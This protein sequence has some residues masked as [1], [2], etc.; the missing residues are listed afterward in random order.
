MPSLLHRLKERRL[1]QCTL[2]YLAGAWLVFQGVEVLAEPWGLSPGVQRAIHVLL[3]IGLLVTLVLAWYHGERGR[4]RVSGTE[5]LILAALLGIAGLLLAVMGPRGMEESEA[6]REAPDISSTAGRPSIAVLPFANRSGLEGD[7]YFTEGIHDQIITQLYKIGGL[8]VRGRT[9][10]MG[11]RDSP[12]R[13]MDIGEELNVRYIVEG[14]VLRAG[15]EVRI[16][17]QLIDASRDE[18]LWAETY[19]Q[20]LAVENLLDVQSEVAQQ[21]AHAVGARLSPG[22]QARIEARPTENLRAYEFYLLGRY[23]WNRFTQEDLEKSIAH[24]QAAIAEDPNYAPAY[25]GLAD[26]Y[27]TLA[28]GH[29]TGAARPVDVLPKAREAVS[30]ALEMDEE[31]ADAHLVL[32]MIKHTFDYDY[33]TAESELR[34]AIEL[35]PSNAQAHTR[36]ALLLSDLGRHDEAI[37]AGRRA[38]LLDPL[39]PIVT[40]DLSLILARARRYDEAVVEARRVIARAPELWLGH[41][42]MGYALML[43]GDYGE[44][45]AAFRAAADLSGG[46]PEA[47]ALMGVAQARAGNEA[48]ARRILVELEELSSQRYVSPVHTGQLYAALE[49][50]DLAIEWLGRA[51]E[52]RAGWIT[53][54]AYDPQFDR[55]R[56][57]HRFSELVARLGI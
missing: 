56:S 4:Q 50:D 17:V 12:K 16:N 30:R 21:I 34:R 31:L 25:A 28:L 52:M 49:E 11:Y 13:L 23:H 43:R 22:E 2:A 29:G 36:Y 47:L 45:I 37:R 35:K 3:L 1:V 10:V 44:A 20:E 57:D 33:L 5:L 15:G 14:G 53:Q 46:N 54:I 26:V 8:S 7:E 18:H 40:T 39:A 51:V 24:F 32:G 48:E 55:L 27:L 42:S 9:S 19:D 41:E 6:L 38:Q